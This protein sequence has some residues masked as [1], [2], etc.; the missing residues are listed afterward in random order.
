MSTPNAKRQLEAFVKI[1]GLILTAGGIWMVG[2]ALVMAFNPPNY[3]DLLS[4]IELPPAIQTA[5]EGMQPQGA[6]LLRQVLVTLIIQG[7]APILLGTVLMRSGGRFQRS[8]QPRRWP[9]VGS[10]LRRFFLP[11]MSFALAR[12]EDEFERGYQPFTLEK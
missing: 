8:D 7:I 2:N 5:L 4:R 11:R 9:G 1:L 3:A 6:V 12:I 10:A